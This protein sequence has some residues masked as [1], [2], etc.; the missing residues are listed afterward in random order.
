MN[1]YKVEAL[2]LGELA[3]TYT[4]SPED[5]SLSIADHLEERFGGGWSLVSFCMFNAPV[6]NSVH[7]VFSANAQ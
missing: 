6:S 4:H 5:F 1:H 2:T 3:S 7:F